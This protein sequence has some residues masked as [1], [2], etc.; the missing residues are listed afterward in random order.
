MPDKPTVTLATKRGYLINAGETSPL[1]AI[2]G[3][4]IV[5]A[6]EYELAVRDE[7][8]AAIEKRL[9]ALEADQ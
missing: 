2:D 3:R 8:I 6:S 4:Q 9:E 7:R 5:E 1:L